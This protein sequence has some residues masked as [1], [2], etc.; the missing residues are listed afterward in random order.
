MRTFIVLSVFFWG[1]G[2]LGTFQHSLEAQPGGG[3]GGQQQE[4]QQRGEGQR[5]EGQRGGQP[6]AAPQQGGR[7]G[8]PVAGQT[9]QSG[10]RPMPSVRPGQPGTGQP[11]TTPQ[12][13]RPTQSGAAN[14]PQPA[15]P[16]QGTRPAAAAVPGANPQPARQTAGAQPGASGTNQQQA[17]P[18]Q[19][20][21]GQ[22]PQPQT[23]QS[24][25]RRQR[26]QQTG[27]LVRPF[28][29]A[30]PQL[31]PVLGFGQIPARQT[32]I[33]QGGRG[34]PQNSQQQGR[35]QM[36]Q[37]QAVLAAQAANAA[38]TSTVYD[39]ISPTLRSNRT[40]SWFFDFDT[41]QD[42]Q[43]SMLEFV[44]G[45]GGTWTAD[46]ASEFQFLDRNGD[47]FATM[48]EVLTSIREDDERRAKEASELAAVEGPPGRNLSSERAGVG[49]ER[50]SGERPTNISERNPRTATD[51]RDPRSAARPASG[52]PSYSPPRSVPAG[53]QPAVE[54]P[55]NRGGFQGS[56]RGG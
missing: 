16:A 17:R 20:P 3:R 8:Q 2:T 56:R 50:A 54:P 35:Q 15:R 52:N 11:G 41:D 53:G 45:S 36:I 7:G 10:A 47:G 12:S 21:V 48:D 27:P 31:A 28:G 37:Q 25:E 4:G 23:E 55:T 24:G 29:E 6:S 14:Q 13:A 40:F 34:Q 9:N 38:R 39:G 44:N 32:Q 33:L 1:I 22:N 18:G 43:L 46:I 49:R 19:P 42:G 51:P 5:G 26:Q 30:R